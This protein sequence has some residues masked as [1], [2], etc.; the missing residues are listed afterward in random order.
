MRKQTQ[1]EKFYQEKFSETMGI[2]C[3]VSLAFQK[4]LRQI[5]SHLSSYYGCR[6]DWNKCLEQYYKSTQE[7]F[8]FSASTYDNI[9]IISY[10]ELNLFF[11]EECQRQKQIRELQT[12]IEVIDDEDISIQFESLKRAALLLGIWPEQSEPG[13]FKWLIIRDEMTTSE[14][15]AIISKII[16][17]PYHLVIAIKLLTDTFL[18]GLQTTYSHTG[19]VW[20]QNS[21][22]YYYRGE[23]AYYKSSKPSI[24]RSYTPI[25]FLKDLAILIEACLFLDQFGIIQQW[26]YS[27]VNYLALA[28]HYGIKTPLLDIT[29][30]LKTALFFACCKYSENH[31]VPLNKQD[32]SV[33]NSRLGTKNSKYGLLYRSPAE[34]TEMKWALADNFAGSELITPIGYQPFSRCSAQ[35]GYM[36]LTFDPEYNMQT[37]LLFEKYLIELNED[38]C[39]WIY[40]EMCK[41]E[42]IY[43]INDIPHIE[44]YMGKIRDTRIISQKTVEIMSRYFKL[45]EKEYRNL[46]DTLRING[47]SVADGSVEFIRYNRLRKINKKYTVESVKKYISDSPR[48]RPQI[49]I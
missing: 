36:F 4:N 30:D 26:N 9:P 12:L 40:E 11:D 20:N 48:V 31:W 33:Q 49:M 24:F 10:D 22:S 6:V 34:I 29:S 13:L 27:S 45:T 21:G 38:L 23:N 3:T 7:A 43:P 42:R 46:K 41:G 18:P 35:H 5:H 25:N 28:Q 47:L 2:E 44:K 17:E 32:F 37:D 19:T 15:D 1:L 16:Y 39:C 14:K 8:L